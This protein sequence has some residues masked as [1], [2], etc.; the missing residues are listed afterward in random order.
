MKEKKIVKEYTKGKDERKKIGELRIKRKEMMKG[1][2]RKEMMQGRSLQE[3]TKGN[4]EWYE[5]IPR[6]KVEEERLI[7][8]SCL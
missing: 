8:G 5:Q 6:N 2:I 7:D 4:G 1:R 3:M